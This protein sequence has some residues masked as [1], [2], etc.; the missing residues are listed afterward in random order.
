[1]RFGSARA[2]HRCFDQFKMS[3]SVF[4]KGLFMREWTEWASWGCEKWGGQWWER[5]PPTA[6]ARVR[7][8]DLASHVGWVC[9]WFSSLPREFFFGSSGFPPSAKKPHSKSQFDLETVDKKSH[10]V[11]YPLLLKY[12]YYYYRYYYGYHIPT[13]II[14]T[15]RTAPTCCDFAASS[16]LPSS[17]V[18]SIDPNSG[19]KI[20]LL[21]FLESWSTFPSS[22]S[23][24]ETKNICLRNVS[25][26]MRK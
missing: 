22:F 23:T 14:L 19:P 26:S 13:I 25:W 5:S 21:F 20:R 4:V 1:M 10:L 9:S 24:T 8:P 2:Q 17:E 3:T 16:F 18:R 15:S 11:E 6:V 7:F 12:H